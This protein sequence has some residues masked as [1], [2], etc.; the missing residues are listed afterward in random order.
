ME[1]NVIGFC[2]FLALGGTEYAWCSAHHTLPGI[3]SACS[4]HGMYLSHSEAFSV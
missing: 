2:L 4:I 3:P 1:L